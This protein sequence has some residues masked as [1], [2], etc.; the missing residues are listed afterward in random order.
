[1]LDKNKYVIKEHAKL[2]SSR[3]TYDILDADSGQPVATAQQS[4]KALAALLGMVF[5][6][7]ATTIEVRAKADNAL[8]F[9]VRRRGLLMKKI[10]AVDADGKVLGVYKA[11][12]LSLSGGFHVY[13]AAGKHLAEIRGKLL[14][15]EYRFF[16][17]DGQ[18]EIGSVS[19]KWG[20]VAKSLF[21]SADTYGVEVQPEFAGVPGMRVL[22]I[23][24][25]IAADAL[26]G[27]K[28]GGAAGAA[29]GG[30][31]D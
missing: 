29:A 13:D 3:K 31:D 10:E 21:T 20:G 14:K 6:P 30:D 5:A 1:M 11:K 27:G 19:K 9:A 2:L 25:A 28:G 4:T 24:A 7:P 23:G 18:T 16:T 12:R 22:V 15:S 17:P 26:F 8:L